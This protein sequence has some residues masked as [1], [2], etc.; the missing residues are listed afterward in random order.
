MINVV[1]PLLGHWVSLL[2]ISRLVLG[3]L[4]SPIFPA[5]YQLLYKWFPQ[6]E[7]SFAFGML[8]NGT[9]VGTLIANFL[10]GYIADH[11]GWPWVFY[12]SGMIAFA[13]ALVWTPLVTNRPDRHRLI[14]QAELDK[15]NAQRSEVT[16]GKLAA[17]IKVPWRQIFKS[18]NV[19]GFLIYRG[20]CVQ[21]FV[22]TAKLPS[23]MSTILHFHPTKVSSNCV[24]QRLCDNFADR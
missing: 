16:S 8:L 1:T 24:V 15:I 18:S 20:V 6:P 10:G 13:G 9:T 17:N 2:V 4:Q 3:V 12:I 21:L 14:T 23:Y 7:R 5:G 11:Y 22:L 19:W